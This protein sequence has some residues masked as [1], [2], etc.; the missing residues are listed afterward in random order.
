MQGQEGGVVSPA[1]ICLTLETGPSSFLLHS[2]GFLKAWTSAT[3]LPWS[4]PSVAVCSSTSS[5]GVNENEN[6]RNQ[7]CPGSVNLGKDQLNFALPGAQ[8][9]TLL[10]K[11]GDS[12]QILEAG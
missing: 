3:A 2:L 11:S 10:S 7:L 9:R 5:K 8:G 4:Q 1:L 6:N 12:A